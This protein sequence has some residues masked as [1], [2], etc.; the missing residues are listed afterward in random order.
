MTNSNSLLLYVTD[1]AASARFYANLLGRGPVEE[2]P[3]FALFIL[4]SG[5]AL[6]LWTRTGVEPTPTAPGGGSELGF[7]VDHAEEVDHIHADWLS[8]GT[9]IV[10]PPTNLDFGRTFVAQDGD[11]HRLR[12]YAVAEE[13]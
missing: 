7:K 3:T 2:S 4:P 10:L 11:G 8:K 6:G 12:V 13:Q 5:L 1:V 9:T